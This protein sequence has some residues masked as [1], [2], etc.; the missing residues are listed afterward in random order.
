MLTVSDSNDPSGHG[1][2]SREGRKLNKFFINLSRQPRTCGPHLFPARDLTDDDSAPLED[3]KEPVASPIIAKRPAKLVEPFAVQVSR[4]KM[5]RLETKD[6]VSPTSGSYCPRITGKKVKVLANFRS[7]RDPLNTSETPSE[8]GPAASP[9]LPPTIHNPCPRFRSFFLETEPDG[10]RTKAPQAT[11]KNS[12]TF[13][14]VNIAKQTNRPSTTKQS[15]VE[16]DL[17]I[18]K[19]TFK[20]RPAE[21]QAV[22]YDRSASVVAPVRPQL[23]R[24]NYALDVKRD[25]VE[26]R[27]TLNVPLFQKQRGRSRGENESVCL[28]REFFDVKR[29]DVHVPTVYFKRFLGRM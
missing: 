6:R 28:N 13:C 1:M 7:G 4:A 24:N 27:T 18:L 22:W 14:L 20:V 2:F 21:R 16:Y 15:P 25:L 26:R 17:D 23:H 9:G 12:K 29:P 10:H 19:S 11:S 3:N 5:Q 8:T